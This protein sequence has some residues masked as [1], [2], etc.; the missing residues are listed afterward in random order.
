MK[1]NQIIRNFP[2]ENIST[3]YIQFQ[4]QVLH[5]ASKF[6]YDDGLRNSFHSLLECFVHLACSIYNE[7]SIVSPAQSSPLPFSNN[8]D[9][10]EADYALDPTSSTSGCLAISPTPIPSSHLE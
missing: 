2:S 5:L 9:E 6:T 7:E 8:L 3:W 1:K 10:T 4:H